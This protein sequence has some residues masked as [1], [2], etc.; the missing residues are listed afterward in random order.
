MSPDEELLAP[1]RRPILLIVDDTPA[2][3]QILAQG[4]M[5]QYDIRVATSGMAALELLQKTNRPDLILLD[6]MMPEMD[7]YEVCRRIKQDSALWDIPV[8][9]V[10]AKGDSVDQQR[11][12]NLG[13]VDYITKPIEI[14]LVR[15]RVGVH[16]RLKLKSE[17]LE[18][19]ALLD[20]LTDIPNR[21]ALEETL[22]RECAQSH[23]HRAPLSILMVDVDHFKAFN[24]CYGHGAGD[25]CLIRVA[26]ALERGLRRPGDFV[27]R[28]GG[29]E[30]IVILPA[31]DQAGAVVIAEHLQQQIADLHIPHACSSA[32]DHV[33]ISIGL[34]SRQ[35]KSKDA[36]Y[37]MLHEADQALYAAKAQ[38]RNRVSVL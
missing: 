9:F 21:R 24:D 11:G 22:K 6:V 35:A 34:T 32:T 33:T 38:G 27:G 5:D 20:G 4:L 3:I 37:E 2:N 23:R 14:P 8:I 19:L 7:G 25:E 28:Y 1:R 36:C 29:E 15:A 31:C 17:R 26:H 12:F 16:V 30:F 10:T 13:A 18:Q